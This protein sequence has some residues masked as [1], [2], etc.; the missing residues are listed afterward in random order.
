MKIAYA[1]DLHL[2]M[3]YDFKL[4][5]LPDANICVLAG[6]ISCAKYLPSNKQDADSRAIKKNTLKVFRE[7]NAK[8]EKIIWFPGNHEYYHGD[9]TTTISSMQT[10]VDEN[11]LNNFRVSERGIH[12]Q[13]GVMIVFATL[14]TDINK[15]NPVD[16][17]AI[18]QGMNDYALIRQKPR[19]EGGEVIFPLDTVLIHHMDLEFIKQSI[20]IS[21]ENKIVIAT[22]HTG[23]FECLD[24]SFRDSPL[25]PAY[26]TP[27]EDIPMDNP[28]VVAWISG[29]TH[30]PLDKYL[31][32]CRM[33]SNPCGYYFSDIYKKFEMK[34]IEV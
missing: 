29:H 33:V 5:N 20:K 21:K 23:Y 18:S 14:W 27:L 34:V 28:N 6:D 24:S 9:L 12:T 15:M 3:N 2:E 22:H 31:E 4:K 19:N 11:E 32:Q 8:Y 10:F 16:A 17:L 26:Y 1:S 25:N 13:D 7:L 30:K